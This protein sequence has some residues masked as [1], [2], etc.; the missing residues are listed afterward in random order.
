MAFTSAFYS[1][2]STI[3]TLN[4][5]YFICLSEIPNSKMVA[6]KN[7]SQQLASW[8]LT[9]IDLMLLKQTDEEY[10]PHSWEALKWIVGKSLHQTITYI[11]PLN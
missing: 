4:S 9:D 3:D 5:V 8:N 7:E 1:I 2:C 10:E 11:T 6:T